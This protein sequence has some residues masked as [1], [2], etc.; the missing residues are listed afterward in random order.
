MAQR[1]KLS[2]DEIAHKV[3]DSVL[4]DKDK[5]IEL[6]V[7][8]QPIYILG[9]HKTQRG[10]MEKIRN[11]LKRRRFPAKLVKEHSNKKFLPD[12]EKEKIVL[13][14]AGVL[15]ILDGRIG[16]VVGE[17]TYLM[18]CQE[19][20]HKCILMVNEKNKDKYQNGVKR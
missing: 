5:Q 1:S 16:A 13:E 20:Q 4:T 19:H 2:I 3:I 10:E 14:K 8:A 9:H 11:E 12:F 18:H 7:A 6:Q 15:V 17:S